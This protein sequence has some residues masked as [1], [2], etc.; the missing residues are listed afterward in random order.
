VS[1]WRGLKVIEPAYV[2]EVSAWNGAHRRQQE[3]ALADAL[4]VRFN[5][6]LCWALDWLTGEGPLETLQAVDRFA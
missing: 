1:G 3:R 5:I 6:L 2:V 4:A